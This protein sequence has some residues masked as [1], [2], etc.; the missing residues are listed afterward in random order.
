MR[1]VIQAA[2]DL[3]YSAVLGPMPFSEIRQM[4]EELSA[5]SDPISRATGLAALV[6]ADLAE[7]TGAIDDRERE[8]VEMVE[9]LGL[10]WLGA[11][12]HLPLAHLEHQLGFPERIERRMS[13]AKQVLLATGDVWW[14]NAI[15]PLLG[16]A[17]Y[18]QGRTRD[19]LRIA[20]A[21]D[22]E[23]QVFDREARIRRYLLRALASLARGALA[24]AE[25]SGRTALEL[26]EPTD[27]LT[28]KA[29]VFTAL[30]DIADARG[31]RDQ[32]TTHRASAAEIHTRKG[33][34]AALAVLATKAQG[35]T[36]D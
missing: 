31:F 16:L 20:D 2:G 27:L 24:E 11:V 4:G 1:E 15:D 35:G 34:V 19:F 36:T 28:T 21:F 30:A 13:E 23:I 12:H 26:A 7:G 17:A 33:N 22:A 6:A 8:R 5:G 9:R 10:G 29:D 3:A 18:G 14:L 25:N 32:A